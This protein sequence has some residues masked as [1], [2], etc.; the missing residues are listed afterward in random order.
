M[1]ACVRFFYFIIYFLYIKY[2]FIYKYNFIIILSKDFHRNRYHQFSFCYFLSAIGKISTI[3]YVYHIVHHIN[4][5]RLTV[6][7]DISIYD[8]FF[9]KRF[10][11]CD[12]ILKHNS[13]FIQQ[14][15]TC[16]SRRCCNQNQKW[17]ISN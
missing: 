10:L 9:K 2:F 1:R 17:A 3:M 13:D 7:I 15:R 4:D 6:R 5:Y 8:A 14:R 16:S 11:C 12:S